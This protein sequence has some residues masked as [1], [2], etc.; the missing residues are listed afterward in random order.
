MI[1]KTLL[2]LAA[3]A[4]TAGAAQASVVNYTFAGIFESGPVLGEAFSGS[5]SY[6][7]QSVTG[8]DSELVDLG[9]LVFT[10]LGH[11][12][13]ANGASQAAFL[14]GDFVGI[15]ASYS[16]AGGGLAFV[17]GVFD[18]AS[19]YAAYQPTGSVGSFGSYTV[20]LVPEPAMLALSLAGLGA[21]GFATTSRRRRQA[22]AAV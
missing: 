17:D 6:N 21:A 7:D 3:L 11:A 8:I 19:A 14:N 13:T 4:L 16:Y 1:R 15:D 12:Y 9:S 22:A 18:L 20:T 10:A 2:A 5:F